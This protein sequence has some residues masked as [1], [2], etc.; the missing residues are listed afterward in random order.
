[1]LS[2]LN[3]WKR[4]LIPTQMLTLYLAIVIGLQCHFVWSSIVCKNEWSVLNELS[5]QI[6]LLITSWCISILKYLVMIAGDSSRL[7]KGWGD[8]DGRFMR[9]IPFAGSQIIV[10]LTDC[11]EEEC[12]MYVHLVFLIVHHRWLNL[13]R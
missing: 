10:C 5:V 3:F 8:S 1:M 11:F 6:M 4:G 9:C 2:V 12:G 7:N 13:I